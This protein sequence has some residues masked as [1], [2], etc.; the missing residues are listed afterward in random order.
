LAADPHLTPRL[1][2]VTDQ[3]SISDWKLPFELVEKI[4]PQ[5]E[6]YWDQY[7][8][9]PKAFVSF[10][11]AKRLWQSRWGAVSLLRT[12]ETENISPTD[13]ASRLEQKLDP[14][15]MGLVFMP[16]KRQGLAASAG[17][18]PFEALF[19]GFSFFLIASAVMLIAILFQLGVEQRAE[20]V[21]ILA[22]TGIRR[23]TIVRLFGLE[24]LI[25]VCGGALLGIICG[26]AYAA[27]M[28]LALETVWVEAIGTP[29]LSL[30]VTPRSLAIA[31]LIGIVVSWVTI[32]WSLRQLFKTSARQLLAGNV[33]SPLS[34]TTTASHRRSWIVGAMFLVAVFCAAFGLTLSG[35]A[36]AGA[37]FGSGAAM[38]VGLLIEIRWRL[39]SGSFG[40]SGLLTLTGLA[41]RNAARNPGR[42]TLTIGLVA[43]ASFLILAVSAFRLESTDAG[44]GG[45]SLLATSDQPIHYD[46]NSPE[47]RVDL[48]FSD[49]EIRQLG[50]WRFL[51]FRVH[52]GEDASCLNLYRPKQP[53]V[54]GVPNSFAEAA[55]FAWAATANG[56]NNP[57]QLLAQEADNTSESRPIPVIL[58]YSTAVYSLHLSGAGSQFTIQDGRGEPVLLEVVGLLKNS[59]LQGELLMSEANFLRLYPDT[60]GYKMFLVGPTGGLGRAEG[61]LPAVTQSPHQL[62]TLL[63]TTLADYGFDAV[64]TQQQLEGFLAVQNTYLSTFQS[65]GALGLLLGTFGLAMV[66]LRSVLERRSELALMRAG[67]FRPRRLAQ[68]VLGENAILLF[69]GLAVGCLAAIVALVPHWAFRAAGV[70]WLALAG[71]L[72]ATIAIGL[73]AAWLATRS[74]LRA[75]IV[76]ALRGE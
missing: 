54:L 56:V 51:A 4:R 33:S 41:L 13:I 26:I 59:V 37:F 9:T 60:G 73:G 55:H 53:R 62:A 72:A 19:L 50:A 23:K 75:P 74:V 36:Q 35:E 32:R 44:T 17:T 12:P 31:M 76:P 24:S 30:H 29:F 61:E 39:R 11:T 25:V 40:S 58:D 2:G 6:D 34:R 48:G 57:W 7:S 68:M 20:E 47:G 3:K 10:E 49:E 22:S 43:A 70:P 52:A 8:T 21:G 66:E 45:F 46:L 16:V 27:L 67:G 63:E 38:L 14:A 64:D 28:L 42:S 15:K 18:T 69:A 65:L 71:L 5:D 1:K